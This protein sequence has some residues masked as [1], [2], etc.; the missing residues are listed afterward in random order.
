MADQGDTLTKPCY[1]QLSLLR[2]ADFLTTVIKYLNQLGYGVYQND[3]EDANGQF[4]INWKYADALKTADQVSFFKFMIKALAEERGLCATFMPKPFK[5]LT[6]NG[7]H[8]HMSLWDLEGKD[9]L[10]LDKSDPRG[11][12][13][14][15]L[16]FL[17]GVIHHAKA[18]CAITAPCVNSYKRLGAPSVRSGA[19]WAPIFIAHGRNNRTMMVRV[20]GAGR[21]E[22]RTA[23]GAANPYLAAT[24]LLAAGMDG[25]AKGLNPGDEKDGNLFLMSPKDAGDAGIGMLP[26]NLGEA[27]DALEQDE[28]LCEALGTAYAKDYIDAKR[29]EW[30]EYYDMVTKNVT[31]WELQRYLSL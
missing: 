28:V 16:A 1:S 2:N 25:I 20:P 7:S 12:S 5:D 10:F 22:Y 8:M 9:N 30:F 19:A 29:S 21:L 17:G 15:A 13:S 24:C 4:E 26:N 23:D 18:L 27:V 31:A 14:V 3:H 11:L 6:G